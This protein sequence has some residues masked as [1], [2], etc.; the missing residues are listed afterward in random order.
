M[1][2]KIHAMLEE[3]VRAPS[4]DNL[5]PWRFSLSQNT[6]FVHLIPQRDNSF[7]N[8]NE[9][10]SYI[11]C[12]ALLENIMQLSPCFSLSPVLTTFP[13]KNDTLCVAKI[14]FSEGAESPNADSIR[15]I[16]ATRATNRTTYEDTEFSEVLQNEFLKE[17]FQ[18]GKFTL[19]FLKDKDTRKTI[20]RAV[21]M[22]EVVL[23]SNKTMHHSFF[24]YIHWEK[25]GANPE[26]LRMGFPEATLEISPS[27]KPIFRLLPSWKITTVLRVLGLTKIIAR[28]NS[29][30]Y[31]SGAAIGVISSTKERLDQSDFVEF[32]QILERLWLMATKKGL[33]F[34]P[35]MGICFLSRMLREG[36]TGLSPAQEK[37]I[38]HSIESVSSVSGVTAGQIVGMFRVGRGAT[39]S[40]ITLRLP[41]SFLKE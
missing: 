23:F 33:A 29:V 17:M 26:D 30:L 13:D 22:N 40:G 2:S 10:G 16:V 24:E 34:H 5:Q 41:P 6:L 21:A 7:Y 19:R 18:V 27:A 28:E 32:G 36:G 4:G 35:L 31:A 12:G 15:K 20:G 38:Q 14:I 1:E 9:Y 11:A 3:A 25:S 8:W 39:P 37:I